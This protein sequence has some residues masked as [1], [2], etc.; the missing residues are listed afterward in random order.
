MEVPESVNATTAKLV[1]GAIMDS[2]V[3]AYQVAMLISVFLALAASATAYFSM[4]NKS[5]LSK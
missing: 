1:K 4:S 3:S 5:K 2:F